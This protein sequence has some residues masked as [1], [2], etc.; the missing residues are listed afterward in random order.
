MASYLPG[1][2]LLP[3]VLCVLIT[4]ANGLRGLLS[5]CHCISWDPAHFTIWHK[6]NVTTWFGKF[7][8]ASCFVHLVSFLYPR[9]LTGTGDGEDKPE[10]ATQALGVDN[11]PPRHQG[12][13]PCFPPLALTG[14][15]G[16]SSAEIRGRMEGKGYVDIYSC[17]LIL[18]CVGVS[19]VRGTFVECW[20]NS[21]APSLRNA[22]LLFTSMP[23]NE[24]FRRT[25]CCLFLPRPLDM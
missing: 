1:S 13:A 6:F 22:L 3:F 12:L 14:V 25:S 2:H 8:R 11:P 21:L 19:T 10:S 18:W 23:V 24:S 4:A 17:W 9:F 5:C 7:G 20:Q 16:S 15:H